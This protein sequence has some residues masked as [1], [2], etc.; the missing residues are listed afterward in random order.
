[1]EKEGEKLRTFWKI[2]FSIFSFSFL[3]FP[4][5]FF[6]LLQALRHFFNLLQFTKG[7]Q[8]L[9]LTSLWLKSVLCSVLVAKL[10]THWM[11]E[12]REAGNSLCK[13]YSNQAFLVLLCPD[14]LFWSSNKTTETAQLEGF[15][16]S[17]FFFSFPFFLFFFFLLS[18]LIK[19][20]RKPVM[21]PNFWHGQGLSGSATQKGKVGMYLYF[22]YYLFRTVSCLQIP[23]SQSLNKSLA[24]FLVE[25][26]ICLVFGLRYDPY[27]LTFNMFSA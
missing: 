9:P 19:N 25:F 5:F 26:L 7:K 15:P 2:L 23:C 14:P 17:F 8:A 4:L 10:G 27:C 18:G 20:P 24:Y 6:L 3:F 22:I 13:I 12:V 21:C 1:M 11:G 16:G